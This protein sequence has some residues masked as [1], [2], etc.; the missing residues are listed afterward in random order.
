MKY[1]TVLVIALGFVLGACN[2]EKEAETTPS[3]YDE[4]AIELN[5]G[6]KWDISDQMKSFMTKS[7]K[8]A[9]KDNADHDKI[10][11][12]LNELKDE[13]ISSCDMEGEGHDVLHSWLLPY[14]DLL[15]EYENAKSDSDKTD[16]LEQIRLA[17]GVFNEYFE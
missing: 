4:I 10:S 1:T 2:S 15:E 7:I 8:V 14:L 11:E 16:A 17:H 6:K 12:E 5:D 9:N 3:I 13:F